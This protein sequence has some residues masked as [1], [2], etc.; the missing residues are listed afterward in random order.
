MPIFFSEMSFLLGSHECL[1][2][3]MTTVLRAEKASSK[4]EKKKPFNDL[5]PAKKGFAKNR[6]EARETCMT[7]VHCFFVA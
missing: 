7:R 5:V 1:I 3:P 6:K 4:A 2:L